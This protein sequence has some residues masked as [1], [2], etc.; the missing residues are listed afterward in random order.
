MICIQYFPCMS[1]TDD[2]NKKCNWH[3]GIFDWKLKLLY[4]VKFLELIWLNWWP[5][6]WLIYFLV[7]SCHEV[8]LFIHSILL[9]DATLGAAFRT[10]LLLPLMLHVLSCM[11]PGCICIALYEV[12]NNASTH[13]GFVTLTVMTTRTVASYCVNH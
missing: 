13:C 5:N 1:K 8:K 10:G 9:H 3:S 12:I 11:F 6:S 4:N 7:H 2:K